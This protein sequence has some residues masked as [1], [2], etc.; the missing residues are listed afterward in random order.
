MDMFLP[1]N[2]VKAMKDA[3]LPHLSLKE[4]GRVFRRHRRDRSTNL[5]HDP[6]NMNSLLSS[7]HRFIHCQEFH[8]VQE[9]ISIFFQ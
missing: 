9:V 6:N 5:G 1:T 2:L 8:G 4:V 7:S 3:G